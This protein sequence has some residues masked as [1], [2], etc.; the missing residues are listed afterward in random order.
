M[1]APRFAAAASAVLAAASVFAEVRVYPHY[2]DARKHPDESRR[3]VKPPNRAE[4]GDKTHFMALRHLS[5]KNYK[6]EMDRYINEDGLGDFIWGYYRHFL[7][8]NFKE[9][10]REIKAR[11]LYYFDIVGFIPGVAMGPNRQLWEGLTEIHLTKAEIDFL[12]ET[13]GDRFL[14]MDN[15]EQDGRYAG[16]AGQEIP[17]GVSAFE[18][19]CAFQSWFER[20]EKLQGNK[21]VALTGLNYGHYF[22]KQNCY[23]FLGAETAQSLPNAQI[24][25]AFIRG[26]GKQYGVPWFGNVSVFGPT[27]WKDYNKRREVV[28]GKG[29]GPENGTSL[30]LMKKLMMA[31]IFY[32]AQAV[33]FEMGYYASD[34]K[35]AKLTPIGQIQKDIIAW[36]KEYGEPGVM[37]APVAV[38]LDFFSGWT[39]ARHYFYA[40][41]INRKWATLPY[42]R[43]DYFTDGVLNMLYPDYD[44]SAYYKNEHG[45]NVDTPYGDIADCVL[46]DA[47]AWMLKQYPLIVLTTTLDATDELKDTLNDYLAS[48]GRI[49]LTETNQKNLKLADANVVVISGDGLTENPNARPPV[50]DPGR[51]KP[52]PRAHPLSAEARAKLDEAFRRVMLFGTSK[53]CETNGLS[54]VTCR[55]S[56]GEYTVLVLNNTWKELPL[57]LHAFVGNVTK[58]TEQRIAANEKTAVGYYPTFMENTAPGRDTARTI[59]PGSARVFVVTL[60]ETEAIAEMPEVVPEPNKTKSTLYLRNIAGPIKREILK[61]P[62]F[63]RHYDSVMVDWKYLMSR[64]DDDL[65]E[66]TNFLTVQQIGVLVDLSPGLNLFPDLRFIENDERETP[67]I[68]H[69][70]K[71]LLEKMAIVSAK[72]IVIANHMRPPN[73]TQEAFEKQFLAFTQSFCKSCAEKGIHVHFLGD[74]SR[75]F[76]SYAKL[77]EFVAKIGEPNCTQAPRLESEMRRCALNIKGSPRVLAEINAPLWFLSAGQIDENRQGGSSCAPINSCGVDEQ[78]LIDNLKAIRTRSPRVVFDAVHPDL[79]SEYRDVRLWEKA[80]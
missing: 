67:R 26:A 23:T 54:I 80:K 8:P 79:N 38:M 16:Y 33:G 13:L 44:A 1:N 20:L 40:G 42:D 64:D 21:M 51:E 31:Q 25:Y 28:K 56:P 12:N 34:G 75:G 15:G 6:A 17:R 22:L 24:F 27:G 14:G 4:L 45:F 10:V 69:T 30:A 72:D 65:A 57:H 53:T 52:F 32:N 58:V 71:R 36:L 61:R 66:Q 47:P 50:K 18:Q 5:E 73:M 29:P 37:H 70:L 11:K 62:T 19:Y 43:G 55:K 39:F 68:R 41:G 9:I 48:G 7:L 2:M 3:A 60:D 76:G 74:N 63:S 35:E 77:A 78:V 59:A 49:V 46:S